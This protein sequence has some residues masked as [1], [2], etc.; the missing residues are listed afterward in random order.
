VL[1]IALLLKLLLILQKL[2]PF[3]YRLNQKEFVQL[4]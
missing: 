3:Q 1:K 4:M 2:N